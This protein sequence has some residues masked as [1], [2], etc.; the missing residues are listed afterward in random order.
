MGHDSGMSKEKIDIS[1]GGKP[2][3]LATNPT[4]ST[5]IKRILFKANVL[6]G[7]NQNEIKKVVLLR[8]KK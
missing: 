4:A 5:L 2:P 6:R 7:N 8:L 3:S 1:P